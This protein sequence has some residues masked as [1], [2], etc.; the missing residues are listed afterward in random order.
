MGLMVG[1]NPSINHVEI[2]IY[3]VF[4]VDSDTVRTITV[5]TRVNSPADNESIL[6]PEIAVAAV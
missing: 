4:P 2:E 5:P 3:H 6:Q 1:L